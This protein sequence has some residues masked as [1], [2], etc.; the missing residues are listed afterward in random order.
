MTVVAATAVVA[1]ILDTEE[2]QALV[3]FFAFSRHRSE[4][5]ASP[6]IEGRR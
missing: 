2:F 3:V 4:F 1:D 6:A 5:V